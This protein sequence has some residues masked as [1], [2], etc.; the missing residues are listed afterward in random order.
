MGGAGFGDDGRNGGGDVPPP[1][2]PP[3]PER[4]RRGD[5]C[6]DEGDDARKFGDDGDGAPRDVIDRCKLRFNCLNVSA[7]LGRVGREVVAALGEG[8]DDNAEGGRGRPE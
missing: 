8:P 2:P 4:L 1:P 3:P 5:E 7:V 6:T